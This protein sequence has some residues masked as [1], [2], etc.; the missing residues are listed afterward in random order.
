MGSFLNVQTM[1]S[2]LQALLALQEVD[3][4]IFK[5]ERELKRLPKEL[6]KRLAELARLEKQ[7]EGFEEAA[8]NERTRIKEVEDITATQRQRQRKLEAESNKTGVDAAMLAHFEHEIR[9]IRRTV[10][11]AE[12][13]GLDML[14]RCEK[15][16]EQGRAVAEQL[17]AEKKVFEEF[18]VNVDIEVKDAQGRHAALVSERDTCVSEDLPAETVDTYRKLLV[19]REGEAL[20]KVVTQI[21][22]GCYVGIPKNLTIKL[23]RFELVQCP[24]C[25][26]ILFI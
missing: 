12:D 9:S 18:K 25:N 21:C 17:E 1:Q 19:L 8:R 16:E 10:S 15:V 13:D 3:R 24:S 22:Q 20:A 23:M 7:K 5:V 26:R 2:T 4:K 6:D 14:E 11:Q